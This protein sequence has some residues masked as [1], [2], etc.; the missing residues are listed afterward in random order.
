MSIC[1]NSIH[2]VFYASCLGFVLLLLCCMLDQ[3]CYVSHAYGVLLFP[4]PLDFL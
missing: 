3:Y 2:G 1:V 4:D